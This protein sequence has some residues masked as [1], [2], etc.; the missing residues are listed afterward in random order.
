MKFIEKEINSIIYL[1]VNLLLKNGLKKYTY[2][3][4]SIY[5]K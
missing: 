4:F 3:I 1:N 2:N 5:I